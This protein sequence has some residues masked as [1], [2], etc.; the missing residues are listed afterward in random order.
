MSPA[1]RRPLISHRISMRSNAHFGGMLKPLPDEAFSAWLNRGL[2]SHNSVHFERAL[3]WLDSRGVDVDEPLDADFLEELAQ[4]LGSSGEYLR[5]AFP[6]RRQWLK[7]L[8]SQ[9]MQF[10][11]L[12]LYDDFRSNLRPTLRAN[13][14]HWWLTVCPVHGCLLH[15]GE[16]TSAGDT[17]FSYIQFCSRL[18]GFAGYDFRFDSRRY[19]GRLTMF[20]KLQLMAWYF[21]RWYM[22]CVDTDSVRIGNV[23]LSVG[24]SE[25]EFVM[26]DILAILGK[27]CSYPFDQR[28][29]IAQLLDIKSWCSLRSSLPPDAGCIPFLCL[30]VGEHSPDVRM[31]M[32]ALLGLILKLPQCVRIWSSEKE[33]VIYNWLIANLW[34]GILH[35]GVRKPSYRAWFQ[36]RS[37]RWHVALRTH[38]FYLLDTSLS[39]GTPV[40]VQELLAARKRRN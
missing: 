39:R 5:Q 9:R 35:D 4:T 33:E 27:K 2:Y 3:R 6:K 30:D 31:A 34:Q 24:V 15:A 14:F 19:W 17:L 11:Q 18:F 7:I 29:Y 20:E 13:W 37:D 10:C 23:Q 36:E 28:S 25:V 8:P 1:L 26:S 12:C 22:G 21:Q 16:S 40:A 32:F 38:F